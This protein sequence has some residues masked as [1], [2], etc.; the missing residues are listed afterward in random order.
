MEFRAFLIYFIS[1]RDGRSAFDAFMSEPQ[2]FVVH[3]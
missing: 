1:H 3:E 2:V